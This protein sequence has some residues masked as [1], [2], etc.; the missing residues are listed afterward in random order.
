MNTRAV[1]ATL[2]VCSVLT[3][4]APAQRLARAVLPEH[5][6]IHLA[7][8]FATDTF[9]GRVSIAVR[10]S[11]PVR[12][13]RLHAAELAFQDVHV[14]AGGVTQTAV[15]ALAPGDE[16]AT[17]TVEKPIPA[18]TATIVMGYT[19]VLNDQLRGFYLSRANN[20]EYAVTQLEA[21]DARRAFPSFDEPAMKATFALSTT[22][23]TRDTAI[24]N[25]RIV[26]DTPGPGAGKHTLRF[27][28]TKRMSP[29]LVALIVGD[30]ACIS[31]SADNIPVRICGAPGSKGELGFALEAA[32]FTLRYFNRYFSIKYPFEKLDIIGVPDFAA[33]AMENTAAIVFREQSLFVGQGGGSIELRKQVTQYLAHE[34]AHQWFGDLVTMAWWD[35]IWLNEGF[36]TWMERR[37][38]EE[39]KPEWQ[40]RLDE[41]RDTQGAMGLDT[42]RNTRPIR[43]R[44]DTPADIN[45]VFDAIAYQKT[46]A[47][48]RMVE[49][50]VGA[51]NYRDGINAYVKK[52]A[53]GNASGEGFW[54]TLAAVTNKPV[55]RILSSYVTQSGMPIV[56]VEARCSGSRTDLSLAQK[57]ISMAVPVPT[58]WD[59]PVC[60]KRARNG[61]VESEACLVLSGPAASVTLDGCS[62]WVFANAEGRG[63]YRTS[64]GTNGLRALGAAVRSGHLTP[65]EQTSLLED[66]WALVR[67]DEEAIADYLSLSSEFMKGEP[68]AAVLA[69]LDRIDFIS[70]KLVDASLRPA[71]ERWVRDS[72]GPHV[73][74]LGW[75][76]MPN[77]SE[78]ARRIRASL[79]FT[80]GYAGRD[81]ELLREARRRVDQHFAAPG[82]LD[83]SVVNIALQLAAIGGDAALYDR[84]VA[85]MANA[86]SRDEAS[87]YRSA[88]AYFADPS[89][90]ART[91][92]YATSSN[93]R[94]QDA[95]HLLGGLMALPWSATPTWEHLKAHWPA[96]Q[97]SVG[98]FQ[99]LPAIVRATGSLCDPA[100]RND[101]ERFFQEQP[102]RGTERTLLQSLETIDRCVATKNAQ[103]ESLRAF[104]RN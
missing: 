92:A 47:V 97:Q 60:Y 98:I 58:T 103:S 9:S 15:V 83:P 43:M 65:I 26:S 90:I 13:I 78:E 33:G 62:P 52:F 28:T 22:I 41:L 73:A 51:A 24:S 36:A 66:I 76:P 91:L 102:V 101:I 10:L 12:A 54:T 16:T 2:A 68:G 4:H 17:L 93:V 64:Y 44:V 75:T 84:Y 50:Y 6:D 48:I 23:D 35:D 85:R 37:P 14:T 30:W 20:R 29:Y 21:T 3:I 31:G 34:I 55:D 63:Y 87:A 46:A 72:A 57:P 25:G 59:I 40:P 27:S 38:M 74:R 5:Y 88:L 32:E 71:F 49:G 19:G 86:G 61:K 94:S 18:G 42:L 82:G 1:M 77:E 96:V 8:D 99:G 70:D 81:P 11:E 56:S 39:W 100:S 95:P 104:L 53:Y 7:P 80:L 79:L 69:V 67:L 45:Q 89:L